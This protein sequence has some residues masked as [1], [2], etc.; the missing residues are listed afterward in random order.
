MLACTAVISSGCGSKTATQVVTVTAPPSA[1]TTTAPPSFAQVVAKVRSGIVRIETMTCTGGEIGTG[2]L[3]S[4]RLVATVEHV[5]DGAET[6][7][8]KENGKVVAHGT[9]VGE[10]ADRDLALI[11]TDEAVPGHLFSMASRAPQLGEDVAALGFPLG[12]PLTVTRGSVSG[13]DRTIPINGLRRRSLVQT[14]AAVNPGNSGGP[15]MTDDGS[16]VGLIDLGTSDANGLAFA[17]SA[18]VAKPLLT[19]WRAAP[20]PVAATSC[21]GSTQT[22]LAQPATTTASNVDTYDGVD[23]SIVYPSSFAVTSAEENKGSYLD[24][25]IRDG[26]YLLRVDE[27]PRGPSHG[28]V[29]VEAAPEIRAVRGESG[30]REISLENTTFEGYPALRWEFEVPE[31]GVVLHKVDTFFIGHAGSEWAILSQAPATNWTQVSAA[32]DAMQQSFVE[33]D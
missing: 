26:D 24:T 16:V 7:D 20:Q 4:H 32:F 2:F 31:H 30:Y 10:D 18:L 19:A 9:V 15:L 6:I 1:P 5:V 17:V 22:Q 21:G 3:L 28:D 33:R 14:D 12:L 13:S 27:T 29:N 11:H 25:T 8:L 23:F